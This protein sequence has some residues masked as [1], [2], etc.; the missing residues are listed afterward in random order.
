MLTR[1]AVEVDLTCPQVGQGKVR[2][3]VKWG[4][5]LRLFWGKIVGGGVLNGGDFWNQMTGV[6]RKK[7][8]GGLRKRE[9][10]EMDKRSY[11]REGMKLVDR[12]EVRRGARLVYSTGWCT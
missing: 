2:S 5:L 1:E 12:N 6:G 10:R 8:D 11:M 4:P 9:G 3:N 7:G